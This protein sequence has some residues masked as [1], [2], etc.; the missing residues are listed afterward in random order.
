MSGSWAE[1]DERHLV[2]PF[3]AADQATEENL[4]MLV[5]GRGVRVS[6][7]RGRSWIDAQAALSNVA[8]GYGREEL[9]TAA[10]AA[11]AEI[12]FATL[13]TGRGHRW[14]AALGERLA[15]LTAPGIERFL[16]TVGGSDAIESAIKLVRYANALAGRPEKR[17]VIGRQGGYHGVSLGALSVTGLAPLREG[18]GPLP[19]Y[20]G[21]VPQAHEPGAAE[22]L[23]RRILEEGPETV[24][25]FVAEPV[26]QSAVV[27]MPRDG[28][29]T[30]VQQICR[31]HDVALV[32]DEVITGFG[33]TGRMFAGEH[34]DIRPDLVT[35]S[36]A[37]TSGYLPLGALGMTEEFHARFARPGQTL[38]HG[39]SG[40]GGPAA[41]AVALA[42]LD[43]LRDEG[44]VER[45]A[46]AGEYLRGRLA[47]LQARCGWIAEVRGIGLLVGVDLAAEPGVGGRVYAEMLRRGVIVRAYGDSIVFTPPLVITDEELDE[48]VDVFE[49][50]LQASAKR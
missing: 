8:L 13:F 37:L 30:R 17:K 10:A 38:M 23:E 47:D 18:F 19:E 22:A 5:S 11:L 26:S 24:A 29:W 25:A 31:E 15:E 34:W 48:V 20:A 14:A 21:H 46:A 36:K 16:F 1:M 35:M 27:A 32:L 41:C 12:G 6:D 50:A 39:F 7:E 3:T 44:L 33:R 45:A 2:H 4:L 40:G 49:A 9:A 28:Y 42:T 43:V